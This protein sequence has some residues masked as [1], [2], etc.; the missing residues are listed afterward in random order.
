MKK[1]V[2]IYIHGFNSGPGDKIEY[3]KKEFPDFDVAGIQLKHE[4][5]FDDFVDVV[6]IINKYVLNN[7]H[8]VGTSLG[9]FYSFAARNHGVIKPHNVHY[10][11]INLPV[12]PY[13][14]L[15]KY[16]GTKLTNY[17]TGIEYTLPEGFVD[18]LI[19]IKNNFINYDNLYNVDFLLGIFDEVVNF[20][21]LIYGLRESKQPYKLE[22]YN[23][24]HR[25]E[26]ISPVVEK[27][28]DNINIKI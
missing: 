4:S 12:S 2:I 23:T 13:E 6:S 27:I 9:A 16:E 26:D 7:V 25:F 8:V 3:L 11:L 19:K 5:P 10:Y 24:D 1:E 18:G 14:I 21:E 15:K 17:K 22:W 20:D 28:K